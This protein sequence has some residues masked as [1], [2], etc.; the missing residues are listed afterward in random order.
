MDS[1]MDD[2]TQFL[3]RSVLVSGDV[4]K[5]HLANN[6]SNK[7]VYRQTASVFFLQWFQ[8][9]MFGDEWNRLF[10]KAGCSSHHP[11]NSVKSTRGYTKHRPKSM[12]RPPPFFIH[13]HICDGRALL[14]LH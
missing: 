14:P 8:K 2:P 6:C 1:H 7:A 10:V 13:Y 11:A 9:R 3:L 12:V 5:G 4:M